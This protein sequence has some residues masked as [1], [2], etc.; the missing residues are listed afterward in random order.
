MAKQTLIVHVVGGDAEA[1]KM[2]AEHVAATAPALGYEVADRRPVHDLGVESLAMRR[3]DLVEFAKQG[4]PPALPPID[5]GSP[6]DLLVPQD[7]GPRTVVDALRDRE[8]AFNE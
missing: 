4:E 7:G 5:L 3:L 8:A 1:R 6:L 2:F